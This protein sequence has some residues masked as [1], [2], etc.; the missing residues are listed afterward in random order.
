M[1]K[2]GK[3]YFSENFINGKNTLQVE[4]KIDVIF[5][6]FKEAVKLDRN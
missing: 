6:I 5:Y 3:Y 1:Q 2:S 4:L